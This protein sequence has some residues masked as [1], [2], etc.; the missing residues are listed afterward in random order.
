[1]TAQKTQIGVKVPL[2][3]ASSKEWL[4]LDCAATPQAVFSEMGFDY[5]EFGVGNLDS[6]E[7]RE[8]LK[9]QADHCARAELGVAFHPY[10]GGPSRVARFNN[11][12]ECR[13]S[14]DR[15][16]RNAQLAAEKAQ[17]R[18]PLV[19][20]PAEES[21]DP[22]QRTPA[23]LRRELLQTS[24]HFA[25]YLD[26]QTQKLGP[27]ISVALEHQV[28]PHP[29]EN[30]I[31]TGDTAKE[32]LAV[33]R[34]TDLPLCWDTGHYLLAMERHGQSPAPPREFLTR[35]AHVHL[36]DVVDDRDHRPVSEDSA[37]LRRWMEELHQTGFTGRITLEYEPDGVVDGGGPGKVAKESLR[38]VRKWLKG[39]NRP[40]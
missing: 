33:V 13:R 39:A 40:S 15:L 2:D 27:S 26:E 16:L 25:A 38:L 14:V 7:E 21:Y 4:A 10:L 1:M 23:T 5:L 32:L 8:R 19:F 24:R 31:R 11:G 6:D 36:H 9:R 17:T 35:V 30:L 22:E 18:V 37:Q 3:W 20:H 28:P 29:D 12:P 34:G